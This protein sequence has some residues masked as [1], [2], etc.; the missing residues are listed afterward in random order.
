MHFGLIKLKLSIAG[1]YFT[2]F[3]KK[4]KRNGVVLH[5]PFDLTDYKFRGRFV[6]N[7]YEVEE[8]K[9]LKKYLPKNSKVLELGGC[10]G[11]VS[12][13]INKA[14]EEKGMQV[15]LEANPKLI[16]WIEKNKEANK[17]SFIVENTII[18]NKSENTFY[19]HDRIVGGSTKRETAE[20]IVVQG[21][22][23]EA[24]EKKYDI[25][26]DTLV[27]DIE[28]GELDLIKGFR[29]KISSF[30]RIFIETHPFGGMLSYS[31]VEECERILM[32]LGFKLEVRD[33]NFQV[34]TKN[35]ILE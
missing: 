3:V 23:I 5:V 10:L 11:Y 15:T 32:E 16:H 27:M 9:Y 30:K 7:T 28:G 14:L 33:G 29:H 21:I 35:V 26:F 25:D 20:P 24:L 13:L 18:S 6:L 19:I 2:I 1:L 8:A 34:W 31:E 22:S 12:C 4:Y 17:C